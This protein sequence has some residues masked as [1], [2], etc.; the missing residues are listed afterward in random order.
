MAMKATAT[1]MTS[2]HMDPVPSDVRLTDDRPRCVNSVVV[3]GLR[4]PLVNF[5]CYAISGVAALAAGNG[6]YNG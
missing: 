4:Q 5:F 2:I 3:N 6:D 1:A